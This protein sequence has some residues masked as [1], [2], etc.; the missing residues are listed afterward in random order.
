MNQKNFLKLAT[1]VL[2]LLFLFSTHGLS[3]LQLQK[4]AT[5]GSSAILTGENNGEWLR[6][7]D[8]VNADGVSTSPRWWTSAILFDIDDL[9]DYDGW[10]VTKIQVYEQ[11]FWT[12][13]DM[14]DN[15]GFYTV[16]GNASGDIFLGARGIYK[17]TDHGLNWSPTNFTELA[18][19]IDINLQN[20][21]IFTGNHLG[22][23]FSNDNGESWNTTIY[24]SNA[25]KIFLNSFNDILIGFWGGIYKLNYNGTEGKQVLYLD[26][27]HII[28]SITENIDGVMFA[29]VTGHMGGE[30]GGVY[31]SND[32][33]ETW[34]L[35]GLQGRFIETLAVNSHGVLFA[36]SFGE[37]FGI[38]RSFDNGDTWEHL[39]YDI[40]VTSVAI[41]P[42]D[43]IYAASTKEH[44]LQGGVFRSAD[45]GD[46]WELINTGLTNF[47]VETLELLPDGYLY[48]GA[49]Y[50]YGHPLFRSAEPVFLFSETP[51]TGKFKV[52]PNPFTNLL[53]VEFP[54]NK[55][56]PQ[57]IPLK[58]FDSAGRLVFNQILPG[59]QGKSI[60]LS[61]LNPGF[62]YISIELNRQQ[63]TKP[64]IKL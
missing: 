12:A 15:T 52:F 6:W 21:D 24:K 20:G 7:D 42:D 37:G 57:N 43:I 11:D 2:I 36:G 54:G 51:E 53:Y 60:N 4:T 33:G 34:K 31:R 32:N 59:Q 48:L 62:Y 64:I 13:L 45:D 25:H 44:G 63:F 16:K 23:F 10:A 56:L 55:T 27:R 9:V 47:H 28:T 38:Y 61:S 50:A 26:N 41:T 49:R 39:K 3:Q 17:S 30:G 35:C 8:G 14:P 19:T 46:T 40:Q 22:V 5:S 29:G 1:S 18:G 58:V